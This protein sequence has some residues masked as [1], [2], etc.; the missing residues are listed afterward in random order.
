MSE[1]CRQ[2]YLLATGKGLTPAPKGPSPGYNT[3]TTFAG[4]ATKR[5]SNKGLKASR[6]SGGRGS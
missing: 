6:R 3:L 5:T 4:K 1:N 2:H